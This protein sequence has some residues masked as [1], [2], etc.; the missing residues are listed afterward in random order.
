MKKELKDKKKEFFL[1][2][3]KNSI[4]YSIC[5]FLTSIKEE[6]SLHLYFFCAIFVLILS[7]IL[8]IRTTDFV[9]V[10]IAL[11]LILIVELVNTALENVVDLVTKE[12]HPLAKKAKDAASAATFMA[13]LLGIL[14]GFYIFI[15]YF[16]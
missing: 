16:S 10:M 15:P 11:F 3:Y 5:G 4:K 2:H 13:V 1:V 7:F 12:Y 6:R 14:M 8:N 9:F